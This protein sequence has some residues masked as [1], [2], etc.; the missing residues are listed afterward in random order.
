MRSNRGSNVHEYVRRFF[1]VPFR[2]QTYRNLAYLLLAF[3]L[4]L[5]YFVFAVV[6]FTV[7]LGL[8]IL[9]I[10][11]LI[12]GLT[13][14]FGLAL[15]SVDRLMTN[16][17]LG[18]DITGRTELDGETRGARLK[19][20]ALDRRTWTALLYLPV[21]FGLGLVGLIVIFVG[22]S[23]AGAMLMV[24]IYYN[25]PGLYVGVLTDRAPEITQTLHLGWNYL[26]V[27]IEG[28]VTI[29]YWEI[30]SFL[31]AVVVAIAGVF[32][33]LITLHLCN[34]LAWGWVRYATWSM[35]GGFDVLGA[36]SDATEDDG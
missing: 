35:D 6:G 36:L 27:T 4:G 22:F 28:A 17:I 33:F 7:G 23:T 5:G 2:R 21:K 9:L 18:T 3:P 26:L 14:V 32:V 8:L 25:R 30:T 12:L 15:A 24:P 16:W 31:S 29:G 10:G 1:A 13:I 11:A 34:G 19:S 20:L